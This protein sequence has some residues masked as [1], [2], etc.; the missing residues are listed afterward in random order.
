MPIADM[1]TVVF[2]GKKRT[3]HVN[4]QLLMPTDIQTAHFQPIILNQILRIINFTFFSR[5]SA[6]RNTEINRYYSAVHNN[7]HELFA[8]EVGSFRD[9][10]ARS[11]ALEVKDELSLFF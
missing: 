10:I 2:V 11:V 3:A 8:L 4:R 5:C 1:H 9:Y 6:V 7:F